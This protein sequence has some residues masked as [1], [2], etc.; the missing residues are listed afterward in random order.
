[1]QTEFVNELSWSF[2]R[3]ETFDSCRR[4]Y[5]YRCYLSWGGWDNFASTRSRLAYR[6]SKMTSIDA[7]IGST[8]HDCISGIL[9]E[10][11]RPQGYEF[12][13]QSVIAMM[14]REFRQSADKLWQKD[15]KRNLNLF[16]D[17]YGRGLSSE[18][19]DSAKAKVISCVRTFLDGHVIAQ[20]H[21]NA[22]DIKWLA[23]GDPG[24]IPHF[25][26]DGIKIYSIPDLA[27]RLSGITYLFEWKTGRPCTSD[28]DQVACYA[29][30]A[31]SRW[32][33]REEEIVGYVVRLNPE[34][35]QENH[36]FTRESLLAVEDSI[37][38]SCCEMLSMIDSGNRLEERDFPKTDEDRVCRW[39]S[40]REVC[41]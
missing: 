35:S 8:V 37:R 17:Y 34:Y 1:M 40:F 29:L 5:F 11:K 38:G 28:G 20:F 16:E 4:K 2:S 15:P 19:K 27:V 13:E 10:L 31:K 23:T 18:Q 21:R 7:Y 3:K 14:D 36:A 33:C 24:Q 32:Q 25:I 9:H 22:S 41:G 26:L 39:C 30:F 12:Q 6:L